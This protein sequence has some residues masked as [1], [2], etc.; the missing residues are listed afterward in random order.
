MLT[1][2]VGVGEGGGCQKYENQASWIMLTLTFFGIDLFDASNANLKILCILETLLSFLRIFY[3]II[4]I[5]IYNIYIKDA[6][7]IVF[8]RNSIHNIR[9]RKTSI[10]LSHE[11]LLNS[12]NKM[13]NRKTIDDNKH[14]LFSFL[15]PCFRKK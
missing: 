11:K 14:C 6:V 8:S 4:Y 13:E 12:T 7:A 10:I 15:Y 9:C 3:I 5:Y 2:L 1:S